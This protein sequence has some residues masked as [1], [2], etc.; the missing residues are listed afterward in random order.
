VVQDKQWHVTRTDERGKRTTWQVTVRYLV[1]QAQSVGTFIAWAK[2]P[3]GRTVTDY[4]ALTIVDVGG[5]DLQQTD[6]T[7]K[8]AYRMSSERRGDGTID[9][10][11]GLKQLL[12]KAKFNDVTAQYALITRQALIAGKMQP[13]ENEV[14]SVIESYGQDLVGKMLEIVQETRRFLIITGGGVLLLQKPLREMLDAAAVT[15]DRDYFLVNRDLAS[16]LNSVGTL[17]A[18]LFMAAKK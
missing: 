11:R 10:A 3:S 8:P 7:L 6:I 15:A 1:P 18:V 14:A 12:P 17:F 5:G 2:A 4:D 16:V 9:I 13:I